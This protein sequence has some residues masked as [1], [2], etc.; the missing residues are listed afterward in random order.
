MMPLQ[1]E[2]LA[3]PA[4]PATH[5]IELN[6]CIKKNYHFLQAPGYDQI[7]VTSSLY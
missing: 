3:C 6:K 5:A 7:I 2:L 4:T 1:Q